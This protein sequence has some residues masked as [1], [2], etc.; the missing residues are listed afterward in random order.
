MKKIAIITFLSIVAFS[1]MTFAQGYIP[2]TENEK[3]DDGAMERTRN[4]YWNTIRISGDEKDLVKIEQ[5]AYNVM[6]SL[7]NHSQ[8]S[9]LASAAWIPIAGSQGGHNS[10]RIRGVAADPNNPNVVYIAAA[11]GGV[12][13][14]NDITAKPIQ[15]INMSDRL[16]TLLCSAIAIDPQ[17]PN[18]LFVGTGESEGDGYKQTPG[19]GVFRSDDGGL[20]WT[21]VANNTIAGNYCAEI[22]IDSTN[23]N[24]VFIATGSSQGILKSSDGGMTWKKI[25]VGGSTPLSIT[26]N[27]KEPT[28]LYV[29]GYGTIYRSIDTGNTWVRCTTGLP[30]SSVGRIT[31]ASAP[32]APN[33]IYASI[34]NASTGS[35]LGIWVSTDYGVTWRGMVNSGNANFI[36]IQQQ[37]CNA[38]AVRPNN[39]R[40]II[41]GGLDI[42]SSA[43]SG[44]TFSKLSSWSPPLGSYPADYVHADI[45]HLAFVGNTLYACT[46]GGIAKTTAP[47]TSWN[48]EINSGLATLQFVGVDADKPFTYVIGGC[49]DNSTNRALIK[50]KEFIA[51]RGGDGGRGWISPDDG[52]ICYTTYVYTTFFKSLD[53][54]KTYSGPDPRTGYITQNNNP[55]LWTDPDTQSGGEGAPFYPA[56]D[57][58]SD[59]TIVAY[60]GNSHVWVS[61]NG[62]VDGFTDHKSDKNIGRSAAIHLSQQTSDYMWAASGSNVW[63]SSNQGVTWLSK[64]V[65]GTVAG[66]TSNPSNKDEVYAVTQGVGGTNKHFYKSID[67]GANFTT[68]ATNFPDIGCWSVAYHPGDGKLFVGTDRGIL[69]SEDGGVTWNPLMNGFPLAQVLTLKIKGLND[70]I[71][72]AGTYGRGM[73][74]LDLTTLD[75]KK[76][77]GDVSSLQLSPIQPN[78]ITTSEATL[79]FT[80]P[81][82]GLSQITL[83]DMLGRE[84]RVLDKNFYN[85]GSHSVLFSASGL[86]KG[87][88]IVG[89]ISNGKAVSQKVIIE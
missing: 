3:Y 61:V 69:Y 17:H 5:N 6:R 38:L 51:T 42:Y 44:K 89:L 75:V 12:W 58:S 15:W 8:M 7:Q 18:V 24:N 88:Y 14:T 20:N 68:P 22:L 30:T 83:Y 40:Q 31:I 55:S 62:G 21:N 4:D 87:T 84:V 82:S 46:D 86:I 35:T 65:V 47:F 80:L 11:S 73:F 43:D 50:D 41:V 2:S 60:G 29:S 32:S 45:H 59:G 64:A 36:G 33:L 49:Q 78:P 74:Y 56:Y 57:V 16:A 9:P 23:S 52:S 53:S 1:S 72:L 10:G 48:T 63:R 34:G 67:G 77:E 71:L 19:L 37:W 66:I 27:S 85:A 81:T 13:K 39:P 25:S 26:Y 54:G 76:T 28:K 79:R 70:N